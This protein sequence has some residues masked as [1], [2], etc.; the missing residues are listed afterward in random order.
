MENS[1]SNKRNDLIITTGTN[2]RKVNN[3]SW[4]YEIADLDEKTICSI[5][6]KQRKK[7]LLQLQKSLIQITKHATA[8]GR[9]GCSHIEAIN[10]KCK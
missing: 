3:W 6:R 8:I 9:C 7:E 5:K 10:P 2:V 4:G 1:N